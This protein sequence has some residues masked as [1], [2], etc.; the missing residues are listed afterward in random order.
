VIDY[1]RA[2]LTL[3]R[4]THESLGALRAIIRAIGYV[5]RRPVTI[6][7][8]LTY[9]LAF[10]GLTVAF[11]WL[12]HGHAMLGTSG[13]LVLFSI[14][15]VVALGRAG[16]K[17]ALLAGQVELTATRPPPP[18]TIARVDARPA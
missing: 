18:R 11:M 5:V 17:V 13:A 14:R 9:W 4:P 1:A 12:A 8:T 16:L 6:L 7:H 3:R 15:Q 10:V 2:E